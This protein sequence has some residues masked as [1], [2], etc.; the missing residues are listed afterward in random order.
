MIP[1]SGVAKGGPHV[2]T[3][4][5]FSYSYVRM[6]NFLKT[7]DCPILTTYSYLMKRLLHNICMK[8]QNTYSRFIIPFDHYNVFFNI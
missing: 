2:A 6:Y 5:L 8:A 1:F 4:L 7:K 3:G